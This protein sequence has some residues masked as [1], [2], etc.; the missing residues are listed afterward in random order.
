MA[1]SPIVREQSGSRS[2]DT[3]FVV[4]M[5][6][7]ARVFGLA[8]VTIASGCSS[9][10]ATS[11]NRHTALVAL[12]KF[13]DDS[14]ALNRAEGKYAL[15]TQSRCPPSATMQTVPL[16][17]GERIQD[18]SGSPAQLEA[19]VAKAQALVAADKAVYMNAKGKLPGLPS[20]S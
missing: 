3:I 12:Q 1:H 10:Q 6:R 18:G 9:G 17:C 7:V 15:A 4:L 11:T 14:N 13:T 8:V 16:T 19:A 5:R 20:L 2:C